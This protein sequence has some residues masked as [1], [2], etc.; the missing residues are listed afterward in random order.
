M[1][2]RV[3]PGRAA[4]PAVSSSSKGE[5]SC[6]VAPATNGR[7]ETPTSVKPVKSLTP[8]FVLGCAVV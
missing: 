8:S 2:V 3:P 7:Y 5:V 6:S 4:Q 1:H